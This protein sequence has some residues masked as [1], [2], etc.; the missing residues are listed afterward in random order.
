MTTDYIDLQV[1]GYH[2]VDFSHRNLTRDDVRGA[3]LSLVEAG[4]HRF[5]PTVIT[6][7]W[8]TYEHVLPVLAEAM[9]DKELAPHLLGIHLEGPFISPC[10]GARGAHTRAYVLAPSRDE[11]DRLYDFAEGNVAL[12]T[13]APEEHGAIDLVAHA[14]AR[15]VTVC[16]GHTQADADAIR[17][18][19]DAGAR[20]ST[21]LGNAFPRDVHPRDNAVWYQLA[22]DEL[23]GTFITDGHHMNPAL[24]KVALRAK[25]VDRFIVVS[26][27]SPVAGLPPGEYDTLGIHVVIEDDGKLWSPDT[28]T[29]AGSSATM[30]QCMAHL[31]SLELLTDEELVRVGHDNPLQLL[32]IDCAW[33]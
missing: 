24:I 33:G 15:G 12:L 22:A 21:H 3:T 8:S 28:G 32:G 11:F 26:D 31:Q 29:L 7:A 20:A 23:Y 5:C 27:A 4:T 1:N 18:A 19:I 2:G 9:R 17:A 30:A 25:G 6:S 14:T 10:D 13:L 16:I